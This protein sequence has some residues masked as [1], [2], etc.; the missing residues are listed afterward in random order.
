[1]EVA[2]SL[3]HHAPPESLSQ[4]VAGQPS[5]LAPLASP[6]RDHAA[7]HAHSG[8]GGGLGAGDGGGDGC[9]PPGGSGDGG[10]S[11]GAPKLGTMPW[12]HET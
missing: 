6:V 11:A 4:G 9:V 12:I 2:S 1:M 5:W 10:G 7:M 3:K 8:G